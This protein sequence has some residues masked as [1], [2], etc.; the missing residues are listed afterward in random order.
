MGLS[1][2]RVPQAIGLSSVGRAPN[3]PV[4]LFLGH[5]AVLM[6]MVSIL[7]F[8]TRSTGSTPVCR[9]QIRK[10]K[11]TMIIEPWYDMGHSMATNIGRTM[12]HWAQNAHSYPP[13][14]TMDEWENL[15]ILHGMALCVYGE[16]NWDYDHVADGLAIEYMVLAEAQCAMQFLADHLGTLWD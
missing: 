1:R 9:T 8:Q 2:V 6:L 7:V 16:E 14:Y 11:G 5:Y 12:L 10:V 15:L 4:P 13:Q 3:V